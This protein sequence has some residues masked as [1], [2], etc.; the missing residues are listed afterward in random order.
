MDKDLQGL[1]GTDFNEFKPYV[2]RG[3]EF[4]SLKMKSSDHIQELQYRKNNLSPFGIS[5]LDDCLGG[6]SNEDLIVIAAGT[7]G[8][9]TQMSM[10]MGIHAAT[11]GKKV[12][13]FALEAYD[14]E[15]RDRMIYKAFSKLFY[16]AKKNKL[17]SEDE[18]CDPQDYLY[19]KYVGKYDDLINEAVETVGSVK[20]FNTFYPS[21]ELTIEDFQKAFVGIANDT[22]LV[23]VDH[24]HY[25]DYG[26]ELENK[27]IKSIVSI[28]RQLVVKHKKPIILVSHVRK[29]DR[30]NLSDVPLIDDLHG[31]SEISKM[32]TKV[33]T[34]GRYYSEEYGDNY[35]CV[36]VYKNRFGGNRVC[37]S[38]LILYNNQRQSYDSDY[39]LG[40]AYDSDGKFRE[41]DVSKMG[42]IPH[43]AIN[44]KCGTGSAK[45]VITSKPGENYGKEIKNIK[46][47]KQMYYPK[48]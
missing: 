37:G 8:G 23:I 1:M 44:I 22:D 10:I 33:I 38:A 31:S 46:K 16:N 11:M 26:D 14:G 9:K 15:I 25:F 34:F 30:R 18:N 47:Q 43:W 42:I 13:Y 24:L 48:S 40:K 36:T 29:R 20:N 6:I 12:D 3:N 5:F 17:I 35:T 27:A 21:K 28:L 41:W 2:E 7:G 4:K 32:A 19:G 45:G 39:I